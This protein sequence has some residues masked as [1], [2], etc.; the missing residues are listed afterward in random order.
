MLWGIHFPLRQNT[1]LDT[2]RPENCT[3]AAL[4]SSYTKSIVA[5][6]GASKKNTGTS[7][8]VNEGSVSAF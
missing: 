2:I 5:S 4:I 6:E 7:F 8:T 1:S 3:S